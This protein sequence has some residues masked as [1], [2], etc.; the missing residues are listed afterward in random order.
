M[1]QS[2]FHLRP[3]ARVLSSVKA[4]QI[5]SGAL[6][7]KWKPILFVGLDSGTPREQGELEKGDN[8]QKAVRS[9]LPLLSLG[10]PGHF[11]CGSTDHRQ[12]FGLVGPLAYKKLFSYSPSL[13]SP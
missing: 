6:I 9:Q 3:G 5:N 2:F 4:P 8:E 10:G 7:E 11:P 1:I 12:V 13:P